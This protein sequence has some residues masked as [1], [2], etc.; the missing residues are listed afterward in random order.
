MEYRPSGKL[1][2]LT[3]GGLRLLGEGSAHVRVSGK[4]GPALLAFLAL[5]PG[6]TASRD[7]LADL[8]W[9]SSDAERSRNSLRQTLTSLRRELA[10]L[11]VLG[12]WQ[13]ALV[14]DPEFV[15]CDVALLEAALAHDAAA[16][17]E[18]AA[19]AYAGPFLDGFFSGSPVF[20]DWASAERERLAEMAV[21]VHERLARSGTG[22]VALRHV[23]RL[24]SIDPT[25]EASYRLHMELLAAQGHKDGAIKAFEACRQMLKREFGVAPGDETIRL[26]DAILTARPSA[27][28][29][30]AH[31][32]SGRYA[33]Q[34]EKPSLGILRF[35][36]LSGDRE[37]DNVARALMQDIV[38]AISEHREIAVMAGSLPPGTDPD[39]LGAVQL[40]GLVNAQHILTG[41]VQRV[42]EHLRVN[43]RLV[44]MSSGHTVWAQGFDGLIGEQLGFQDRITQAVTLALRI[45]LQLITWRVRDKSPPGRP[46]VR[47][48]VNQA[49]TQYYAMTRDSLLAAA[50]LARQALLIEPDNA[51]AMRTLSVA[52]TLSIV[53]G[54]SPKS[55]EV[56]SR[57]LALAEA[58]VMAVPDDEM[59]RVVLAYALLC[60]GRHEE[61]LSQ[62]RFAV[63]LNP[64]YPNSYGDLAEQYALMG[65]TE[66]ALAAAQ[67]ALRLSKFDPLDFYRFYSIVVAHF[68]A[69][70]DAQA[71][72]VVREVVRA[73]PG[74]IVGALYWAAAA[75]GAGEPAEAARA[76]DHLLSQMPTLRVGDAAPGIAPRYVHDR[77]HHRFLAMLAKAGLPA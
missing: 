68:A 23:R 45:E 43:V 33:T 17:L 34:A 44:E 27:A 14:L 7:K 53:F 2:I 19:L 5:C 9:S 69:G 61:A 72:Q 49:L 66:E 26:R 59:S 22:E 25:R 67:D 3:F 73:K 18:K 60:S 74:F 47:R 77:H 32:V 56:V 11:G 54:G 62:L 24:L 76:V 55:A 4:K 6:M 46:E 57:A 40:H 28:P 15:I 51:R 13:D 39:A 12:T 10:E 52:L 8:L 75:A 16:D 37:E 1:T 21:S 50:E 70:D 48:L 30:S 63:D 38:T 36:S 41:G 31:T 29:V 58:A 35:A 71:L 42:S 65:R 20:D 64:S